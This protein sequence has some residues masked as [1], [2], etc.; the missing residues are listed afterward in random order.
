MEADEKQLIKKSVTANDVGQVS[1]GGVIRLMLPLASFGIDQ[2]SLPPTLPP[3]WTLQ[4]DFTLSA[5]I[6]KEAMWAA[7]V[8]IAIT[9]SAS[10][11]WEV[12][13]E[14]PLRVKRTQDLLLGADGSRV[15][16]VSFIAK[17]LRDFLC[18]DNGAFIEIVRATKSAGSQI[19]GLRHL[20]SKRCT[21]TGDPEIP[22]IYRDRMGAIHEVKDYQVMMLADMPDPSDTYYGVGL[23]AASRAYPAIYKLASIEWYLREKVG[24]LHP[25]AI[26]IVNGLLGTQIDDAIQAAKEGTLGKGVSQYMGAVLVGIPSQTTPELVTIPLAELPDGFNRKE[27]F[28]ISLLT[29]ADCLGLDPQDLQPLTGQ[30]LGTGAQSQVLSDKAGGKG[31]SAWRQMFTHAINEFVA[32]GFTTF[33]FVEKDYRDLERNAAVSKARAD[34]SKTRIDAGITTPEQEIQVLIDLDEL[35]KEFAPSEDPTPGDTLSDD[36]KPEMESGEDEQEQ[37]PD[38]MPEAPEP[39]EDETGEEDTKEASDV[40]ALVDGVQDDA[41]QLAAKLMGEMAAKEFVQ[42][43]KERKNA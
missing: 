1:N 13:S 8:G 14:I 40:K 33:A 12:T 39:P 28:D 42:A 5:T 20:D 41:A 18:T 3:Y 25:L 38:E 27:E 7:A 29:Y 22:V 6:H 34:V 23:C 10:L 24:G 4:R 15:G 36:E 9:K 21:R 11:S 35:P 19:I 30:A 16:W 43:L 37:P 17:H 31:L 2:L 32:P 26:H